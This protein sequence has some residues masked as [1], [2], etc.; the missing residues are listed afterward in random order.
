MTSYVSRNV[1]TS[2]FLKTTILWGS[3]SVLL[4]REPSNLVTIHLNFVSTIRVRLYW[5]QADPMYF[6]FVC[7]F[8]QTD[9]IL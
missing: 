7:L 8:F 5:V 2:F 9:P 3:D 4:R 6:L 1:L